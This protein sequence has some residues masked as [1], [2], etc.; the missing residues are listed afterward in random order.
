MKLF[1]LIFINLLFIV[2]GKIVFAKNTIPEW[3]KNK[4]EDNKLY[5]FSIGVADTL[6]NAGIDALNNIYLDM[7]NTIYNTNIRHK[8]LNDRK[9]NINFTDYSIENSIKIDNKFY[10]LISLKRNELYKKQIEDLNYTHNQI[11]EKYASLYGNSNF[12]KLYKFKKILQLIAVAKEK[13][14]II[15]LIDKFD[16][17]A[18]LYTYDKIE[19]N[20]NNI[21][22]SLDVSLSIDEDLFLLKDALRDILKNKNIKIINSSNNELI[23]HSQNDIVKIH[24]IFVVKTTF[25]CKLMFNNELISFKVFDYKYNEHIEKNISFEKNIKTF[26]GDVLDGGVEV[27][28]FG[29]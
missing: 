21:K 24:D 18:Y 29:F 17:G 14:Q 3:Y 8:N 10:V 6:E 5:V 1:K 26:V 28:E 25:V 20:Y 27:S 13:I 4:P 9:L 19:K 15:N 2:Y 11:K 12:V 7:Y 16:N 22:N 23:I